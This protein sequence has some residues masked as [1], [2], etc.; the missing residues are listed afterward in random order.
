MEWARTQNNLG[1]AWEFRPSV[2][3]RENL[4]LAIECYGNAL[5][6]FTRER[7]PHYHAVVKG[8]LER[9]SGKLGEA[10]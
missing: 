3:A 1:L 6:V 4:R 2:D 8:N 9:A 5:A 10:E 7:F